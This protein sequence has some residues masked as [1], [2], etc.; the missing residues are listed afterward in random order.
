[1]AAVVGEDHGHV[2][3][4]LARVL[5]EIVLCVDFLDLPWR[6]METVR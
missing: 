1:M 5:P 4:V 6:E 2:D 3:A